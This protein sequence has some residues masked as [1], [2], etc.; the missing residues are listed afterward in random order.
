MTNPTLAPYSP[1]RRGATRKTGERTLPSRDKTYSNRLLSARESVAPPLLD[2]PQ[3]GGGVTKVRVEGRRP[4]NGK[5]QQRRR[6]ATLSEL[7]LHN[8][9]DIA[10]RRP[11]TASRKDSQCSE[12][13]RWSEQHHQMLVIPVLLLLYHES[14]PPAEA[15]PRQISKD[16]GRST[17]EDVPKNDTDNNGNNG[18]DPGAS[19]GTLRGPA[20]EGQVGDSRCSS[21]AS[22]GSSEGQGLK[23][24]TA[25]RRGQD[26]KGL[27]TKEVTKKLQKNRQN[28]QKERRRFMTGSTKRPVRAKPSYLQM[29]ENRRE[30]RK[31]LVKLLLVDKVSSDT[32]KEK[33]N[34]RYHFFIQ[35]GLSMKTC[36]LQ[37]T[38]VSCILDLVPKH[39]RLRILTCQQLVQQLQRDY[40]QKM[41]KVAVDF[42]LESGKPR[43]RPTKR[44]VDTKTRV[45][46]D[47]FGVSR[48]TIRRNL[49]L[50]NPCMMHTLDLWYRDYSGLRLV[51]VQ[52]AMENRESI[53]LK[54][55]MSE[56]ETQLEEARHTLAQWFTKVQTVFYKGFHAHHMPGFNQPS[57]LA[58]FCHAAVT[59]MT[60]N[61]QSLC[62]LSLFTLTAYICGEHPNLADPAS[63]GL[64]ATKPTSGEAREDPSSSKAETGGDATT[65]NPPSDSKE[66]PPATDAEKDQNEPPP[67]SEN[68]HEA[69]EPSE[70]PPAQNGPYPRPVKLNLH[71]LL[72]GK[73][74]VFQPTFREVEEE[75]LSIYDKMISLC[76]SL[77][78]LET[79]L[80]AEWSGRTGNMQPVVVEEVVKRLRS[81]VQK[82]LRASNVL[83]RRHSTHY[84]Q[85]AD[86]VSGQAEESIKTFLSEEHGFQEHVDKVAEYSNLL[87][88]ILTTSQ[89]VVQLGPYQ[90]HCDQLINALVGRVTNIRRDLLLAMHARYCSDAS[91]LCDELREITERALSTPG[92]TLELMAHKAYMEKIMEHQVHELED[93]VWRLHKQLE[94]LTEN[95]ALSSEE[96]GDAV[97][98]LTWFIRLPE[99][100]R[101]HLQIITDKRAE[102]EANLKDRREK[103]QEELNE[104]VG[105]LEEFQIYGDVAQIHEYLRRARSLHTRLDNAAN[106]IDQINKE[107]E[108]LAWN[109]THYPVRK[110]VSDRL[111]PFLRLY[112]TG[113]DWSDRL[114]E[115]L[116]SPVGTHDPD[117]IAQDVAAT[118]RT[119]YKLEKTF[120]DVPAA[121]NVVIAVRQRIEQFR[122]HLPLVQTLGNPGLK[123]RHWEKI[124]EVVGYPLRADATTTM[125]RLI[126]SNL[127]EYL[128]KFETISEAASKEHVFERNL[129]KMKGEWSDMELQLRP[130][131][132]TDTWVLSAVEDIQFL[133]DDHIVKTQSMRSSPFI[134]PIEVEVVAWE[135][136]LSQLQEVL[137][138]WLRVQATW[139][140]L[141]P[142]FGSPDIMA[143]MPEEGRRFNTVDKTWK[144]IMKS[145][146]QNTRV[147]SILDVDKILERLRK[148]SELLE[149]I[150]RGL[151]EYL[152]KKRLYFPRFFF[153]SNE[154]LLEIL[155][156]TKD[157]SRV[158]PHLKKC[159]EGVNSLEFGEDLEVVAIKSSEGELITLTQIISTSRARGQV[160]KWLV[161]LEA[162]V[163]DSI[164]KVVKDCMEA[165]SNENRENWTLEWPGQAVL[166]VSQTYWT[167]F[168]SKAM[169]EG[170]GALE[171]YFELCNE[172]IEKVVGLVRGQLSKQNRITLGALVVLDVHSRD[173]LKDE[174]IKNKVTSES[175]FT[176]LAQ[177]RYYWQGEMLRVRMINAE[178]DYGYEYLGNTGRLVITSLTDR[179]Y[180]TLTQAL[181]L[182]LGGAPEGPA[183]T[184]KTETT[185]DLAKAVAKQCVVFN[186]SDGL[187]YISLAKFFKG[188]A[189]CGAWTCFDEFN[190]IELEVLSVVA[191]QILTL[192]RGLQS[193]SPTLTLHGT[194]VVLDP[195]C[196]VFIT[197]NP[198]Y[199][200]RS[201]LPDNLKALFRSVA[202]MVPDYGLI[203]EISL[204][205][206]GFVTARNLA[207]KIVATYRLCSEQL[208]AQPHYDYGMRTVKAVLIAAGNLKLKFP[209]ASEAMLVLRSIR[210]VNLPKF[211]AHDLPLFEGIIADLFP[212]VVLPDPDYTCLK[213]ALK[214]TCASMGLRACDYFV[215]KV[216][217]VY[218][219]MRVRHGFM[220][221]G[222]SI[223]GKTVALRA[224][225]QTLGIMN[226]RNEDELKVQTCVI[227][228]K[229][230][231]LGQ[232]YGQF[233]PVSHEWSDGVLAVTFR[234]FANSTSPDRKWLV[235]D[236]PVDSVWIESINSVLDDNKK[237][238]L[239]S[240]EIIC[241]SSTT[242]LI[243]EVNHLENASPATVSRCGMVYMEPLALGWKPLLETWL[244]KLPSTLTPMHKGVLTALYHRFM[245]PLL[246]F[247]RNY[248]LWFKLERS[249][250]YVQKDVSPTTDLNLI[251]SLMN[252][253]NCFTEEF[254]DPAYTKHHPESD[255][256][257]HLESIFF[258]SAIWALGGPLDDASRVKFDVLFREL[259]AGNPSDES[260]KKYQLPEVPLPPH[261]YQL[262][263]P[264]EDTVFH[265]KFV[266][267]GRGYWQKWSEDL[268]N[269]P[270]IPRDV[271]AHQILVP[272]VT[273]VRTAALLQLLVTNKNA[274]LLVGPPATGKSVY[275]THFLLNKLK[276]DAFKPMFINF[277][278]HTSASHVQELIMSGL[279]K[280]KKGVYGP[281]IGKR[282]VLFVDDL[283][284]PQPDTYGSHPPLELL[285]QMLDHALWYDTRREVEPIRLEDMQ[286]LS[287]M[288]LRDSGRTNLTP[289]L[290][291]HFNVIALN[292]FDDSTIHTIFSKILLW[293]LDTRGFSKMFDPCIGEVVG[294][295]LEVYRAVAQNLRPTPGR[296]HY[297]FNLKD[298]FR[299]IQGVLL[300]VPETM[301]DLRCMKRLWIHEVLRVFYDRL[302]DDHD[303]TWLME[304]VASACNNHLHEDFHQL[305][306]D[307]DQDGDG[308]VS[309]SNLRD[310]MY[311]DFADPKSENRHYIPVED[312]EGLRKVVEG[313]LNE[314]NNMSKKPMSLVMFKFA[315]EH[316]CRVSRVL[317]QPRG[318]AML[319][320]VGGSGRHS[321]T[322]LAAHIADYELF[323]V[324][325]NRSYGL[326]EW[327]EDLKTIIKKAGTGEQHVVFLFSDTQ[328]KDE[329][330]LEAISSILSIGEVPGL[331]PADE[332]H[333]ICDKMRNIDR[334][335]DKSRQTD[336][337][338]GALWSLF[339][340]RVREQ[341]NVVLAMSPCG[342]A[343]RNRLRKFPALLSCCTID[344]FQPW[345]EDALEAVALRLLDGIELEEHIL[346]GCVSLCKFFHTSTQELSE[347]FEKHLRRYNY[348][349]PTSYLQLLHTYMV[350]LTKRRGEVKK[351]ESRYTTGLARLEEAETSVWAMQQEL[352]NLQPVLLTKTKEVEEKMGV[353]EK[354]RK[355]VA[356]VERVV[357]QDE[358]V[359]NEAAE[360]ANV[361]RK[362]CEAELN[363]AL[364]LL[365][366][367]TAA[368]NTIKQDDIV[369]IKAMK[370][371]PAGVKLVMEAVCVLLGEKPDRVPDPQG[372]G[373]MIE[374]FWA[375]S[376]RL[377][378]DIKFK[379]NL[380]NFD[381]ENISPKA[382][383]TIRSKYRDNDEFKP[384]KI[385]IASKA[386][387]SLCKWVLAMERYEEVDR[388][389]APKRDAL[390]RADAEYQGH[391]AQLRKKQEALRGVQEE[392]AGLQAELDTVKKEKMELEQTVELCSIKKDRAEQLLAALGGE[393]SRWTQN[394]RDLAQVYIYLI[395]DMLLAAGVIAYLGAFTPEYRTEQTNR[396][397]NECRAKEV[398]CSG[399]FCLANVLGDPLTIR[400][401][402]LNGLPTDPFSI[403]NGVIISNTTRWP[404]LIDPQG[405]AN[406]WIRSMEKDNALQVVKLTDAD[407]IRTLEN[408]VQFGQP[409]LLENV[410]EDLDPILEP[411]LLK[412]TF[413]Q[414]GSTCIKL[415]DA[416]IEYSSE[417]RMY[418]TTK[419]GN[420]NYVPE[421]SVKVTLVNFALTG[422]GLEDQLLALVVAHEKPE[423]EEERVTLM[424]QTA[425]NKKNLKELED[426][427]LS[428][429]SSSKGSILEDETAINILSDAKRLVTETQEKQAVADETEKKINATR[430]GYRPIAVHASI[431]FFTLRDLGALDPMYQYSLSW[432]VNLFS[433]SIDNS[434]K[435]SELAERLHALT[436]HFTLSLY[437]NVCTGLFEKDKLVFSF[438][439]CINLLRA[440]KK[441]DDAEWFFLLTGGLALSSRSSANP[442][443]DWLPDNAWE[444]FKWLD[445]LPALKC[446]VTN[447]VD[448]ADQWR[449]VFES[450]EPHR[451]DLPVA[452]DLELSRL[453]KLCVLRCLRPDKVVAAVQDFV[454]DQL[455]KAYIE[456]PPFDLGR[457]FNESHCCIP[458]IFLLTPGADP[459]NLLLKFAEDQGMGGDRTQGVS[460]GQG[461]GPVAR[462]L[463]EE[464]VRIGTWVLL[465]NCHLAKS[466]MPLLEKLCEELNPETT[467]PDFRLWLTSYPSS[468]FPVSV[469]QNGIKMVTEPPKGLRA[470]LRRLY[471]S[472]P[473]SEPDFFSGPGSD[474][475]FRRLVFSLCFFHAVVQERRLFGP[476]GWNA[477]YSF[478]DT[479]LRISAQQL[480]NLLAA[481]DEVPWAALHYLT[482]ECNYG[483]KV[484]DDR[485]R[486]CLGTILRSFYRP[487]VVETQQHAFDD[488]GVYLA[489]VDG[490]HSHFL[491]H[492][493]EL[494]RDAPAHVFGMNSN[495]NITKDQA[496]TA[497][498][499]SAVLLTQSAV[500]GAGDGGGGEQEAVVR[501]CE[502]V[503]GRLP[504]PFH[505]DAALAKFPTCREQSL[506]TVLVQEMCRYNCLTDTISTSLNAVMRALSGTEG[507]TEEVEEVLVGARTGRVP[508]LWRARSY[509]TLKGLGAYIADLVT[510]LE[511]LQTWYEKG[512]PRVIWLSGFFFT[513]SF[514]TGVLQNHARA[515]ALEIDK[516]WFNF[517]MVDVD[518]DSP[519]PS[520][521]TYIN[522]LYIEGA[523]WDQKLGRLEEAQPRRLHE[524]MPPIWLQ[525][526]VRE[527]IPDE[528]RYLCPVYKT[529]ERKGNLTT[530]GHS[531][532]FVISVAIPSHL[533][534]DHWILR[535]VGLLLSLSD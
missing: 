464:G 299:V 113:V 116:H 11:K 470:N 129:E 21:R 201:E 387:E 47:S 138:E 168:V 45:K 182:N 163:K 143:Q 43:T 5:E 137:D 479:D 422:A 355:E 22:E 144:D 384:E 133:L 210:D 92:D 308:E 97:Q 166:C 68:P 255:I 366:E 86:L 15:P 482:A 156:E 428:T 10:L 378:G 222:N 293:H 528:G 30:F 219:T 88:T 266:K 134:K 434:E 237:L 87:A 316:L 188:L 170:I 517:E 328:V 453:Q 529:S 44:V 429:L 148:S 477:P 258:F 442:A 103:F 271:A 176:W 383:Q 325:M 243:F 95:M 115:W 130:H 393:K 246:T 18:Q 268:S 110:Q 467:H 403:D 410:G 513:Q 360:A 358:E 175:D 50:L 397:L 329:V 276:S 154:E 420:P 475:S 230:V 312:V 326:T 223:G 460:L 38:W 40:E 77:P 500:L 29:L 382:I 297:I 457:T 118:W 272:T 183:G 344:W 511:F 71:L 96:C 208:S 3:W 343:F 287:A 46:S 221:I 135:A 361:I 248:L 171:K 508:A 189:S 199:A 80:F 356:E 509:P 58:S 446:L 491:S 310:L 235:L 398:P 85:Y 216:L 39:L 256:R 440:E 338:L 448:Q 180:R 524:V 57:R 496:E 313:Y 224:L 413:K 31:T 408:C 335:R 456:A 290:L 161:Q 359:A 461:Q 451:E 526:M 151:N 520:S 411:L 350:I 437:H 318:H 231:T 427:I 394:A 405:Q 244:S 106:Y 55:F 443:P 371:P 48:L 283:N 285:R 142:I 416:T 466:F 124:S 375:V 273:M 535:G 468:S 480:R 525:P 264:E 207:R 492:I 127:E 523:R 282:C 119:V 380:L 193:K 6:L 369:F 54:D 9:A 270:S 94:F 465:Q 504:P 319:V 37:K 200:G 59:I 342:E 390:R 25:E 486:R 522:G 449:R 12:Y 507:L 252:L 236:G 367:A 194:E 167:A 34:R 238:C 149:L 2:G 123:E 327:R 23:K 474:A 347:K 49:H 289:R 406:K 109:T 412:Q 487:A 419:L 242:N 53:E 73:E 42:V 452:E 62:L 128:S 160:E 395:G 41:R 117:M 19:P 99:V 286:I 459:T 400:D 314:F 126:D 386:A 418:L 132:E 66:L 300:S 381:K 498:L 232:L 13:L 521:G 438:L 385:K 4:L 26:G 421:V 298:F 339:V 107:E 332:K 265:Y 125:Q 324:E 354:R 294:G 83:P 469:L 473:L 100:F 454:A 27:T 284:L 322:R 345:P 67:V 28:L 228:P 476:L 181:N 105:Q 90:L 36:P 76:M 185:K 458:L 121:K 187:D 388:K 131:R 81:Q 512:Q 93:Q 426:R 430:M 441:V 396:W 196:A 530:T 493:E 364:P 69:S 139:T 56:V 204:Y 409:V 215:D 227:N 481:Y 497:K 472:D 291:R 404:L 114:Q 349:T 431:L 157:P 376:K 501:T 70:P 155:S 373:K 20:D 250:S 414:S 370:N 239:M 202:M 447:F 275:V 136:M 295:T 159:F 220:V 35:R 141:E 147:L 102:Y 203:A 304:R 432:F 240:G 60:H 323:E 274:L 494:P 436:T 260:K 531:T 104:Y 164:K 499:F 321:L 72:V 120:A 16:S 253:F 391:M 425:Q 111:A 257:A 444:Q 337:S 65:E 401:W 211:L 341:L 169:G 424:L 226:E 317:K 433:N 145:V 249:E 217:E 368:L 184:G 489:P 206:F 267:E 158:Q 303:R 478:S 510:R 241:L 516:L 392:L 198:G 518:E 417:F 490:E 152:E 399:E 288:S 315:L 365:E 209:E 79:K 377:L 84:H 165:Y 191:Q 190:R 439:M 52:A 514:L 173:V 263:I 32:A 197:M 353:V 278:A 251:R 218:E 320:G 213:R 506:N 195:T 64:W 306:G 229:A 277:S 483:G 91:A 172:Q 423:L 402:T 89:Q 340:E 186:C 234:K 279:D 262:P 7:G 82:E 302:V 352:V 455:G 435:A 75:L 292:D 122:E 450:E 311:C 330:F 445:N 146:R 503:L 51:Q 61:V 379:E 1:A 485:D 178:L 247:V 212:D 519:A 305:L 192:Q 351:A 233:D 415:G 177:L 362:E 98:P 374:D 488:A 333:T 533:P 280:R 162:S 389:V 24:Y 63:I 269:A 153:L 281:P 357:R 296:S 214:E 17:S 254:A 101:L 74:V 527:D 334:Q 112:E 8:A 150:Q 301:E 348:V 463:I 532:N 33:I 346:D 331:F 495:A 261:E 515:H 462:K 336:G 484:T 407:F 245:P 471:L 307:L 505:V 14:L 205:S 502:E 534:Q 108:A 225:A 179:C 174:I 140:Y 363:L 259:I 309:E 78:R 372:T